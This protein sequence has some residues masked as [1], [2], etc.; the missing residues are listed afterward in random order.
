MS[1]LRV[2]KQD[3]LSLCDLCNSSLHIFEECESS[4][5]QS[6]GKTSMGN[7]SYDFGMACC[8]MCPTYYFICVQCTNQP[9][10]N[11]SGNSVLVDGS[12]I[13]TNPLVLCQFLGHEECAKLFL[14][15]AKTDFGSKLNELEECARISDLENELDNIDH[16][17]VTQNVRYAYLPHVKN[18][19]KNCLTGDDGGYNHF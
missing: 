13:N 2:F 4:F 5:V 8:T 7:I 18:G 6:N 9:I 16:S 3:G 11:V 14:P 1:E 10:I 12:V 19:D 15:M 17:Y